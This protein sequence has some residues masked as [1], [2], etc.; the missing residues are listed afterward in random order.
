M[1][2]VRVRSPIRGRRLS[3]PREKLYKR[4]FWKLGLCNLTFTARLPEAAPMTKF[5]EL[6]KKKGT[7]FRCGSR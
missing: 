3:A 1:L 5:A 7:L 6:K 2:G 4:R